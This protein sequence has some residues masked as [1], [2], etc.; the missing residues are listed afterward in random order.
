MKTNKHKSRH[1]GMTLIELMIAMLIG[2]VLIGGA[3][4][5]FTQSRANFKTAD[6]VSRLQEN[7]RYTLDII[8]PDVRLARFW[9]RNNNPAMISNPVNADV[10]CAGAAS[11]AEASAWALNFTNA[12]DVYE[13]FD[14]PCTG[15]SPRNQSDVMVVRHA[16]RRTTDPQLNQLQIF[17]TLNSG[18][19]FRDGINP[20]PDNR[21]A[22]I[23]D[24]VINVYYVS[25]DSNFSVSDDGDLPSL[26]RLTLVRGQVFQD[27]EIMPGIENLQVQVGIDTNGDAAID[28]WV[29]TNP[30][31][32]PVLAV[33]LWLLV[34]AE[35]NESALGFADTGTYIKPDNTAIS[36]APSEDGAADYPAE[37]RRLA[38]SQTVFLRNAQR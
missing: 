3:I 13:N 30:A 11:S 12:I 34:R 18:R 29:N 25:N 31:N 15:K 32:E 22:E 5:I 26:R 24:V 1:A 2:T 17:S 37:Y 35:A 6:S 10:N 8:K 20:D 19:L 27:Q 23:R 33:R 38:V 9:G 4:T 7:A 21:L 16:A 36:P 28:N 14:I